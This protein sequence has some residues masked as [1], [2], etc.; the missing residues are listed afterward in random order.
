MPTTATPTH[1]AHRCSAPRATRIGDG[2]QGPHSWVVFTD[3][4][5]N[6]FCV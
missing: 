5:G 1:L 2:R 3:P 4:E 6:E